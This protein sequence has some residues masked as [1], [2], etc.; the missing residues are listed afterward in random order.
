MYLLLKKINTKF[1]G[2]NAVKSEEFDGTDGGVWFRGTESYTIGGQPIL[3]DYS[4]V[5]PRLASF[6]EDNGYFGEPYDAGTLFAWKV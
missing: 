1:P 4:E 6:L 2:I 3:N 5:H